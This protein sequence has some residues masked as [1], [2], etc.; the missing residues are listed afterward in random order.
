MIEVNLLPGASRR[1][2]RRGARRRTPSSF[3]KRL[4]GVDRIALFVG[5]AWI[6]SLGGF[7]WLFLGSRSEEAGLRA[8]MERAQQDS[9]RYGRVVQS[10]AH[11]TARRDTI[12][13]KLEIIQQIDADRYVW[14]HLMDEISRALPDYTWIT[15]LRPIDGEPTATFQLAGMTG[16]N[17][18]LTELLKNLEA[19]P[20]V[21][22]VNLI[23]TEQA[24]VKG[25]T[26]Y[27][28]MLQAS[29]EE[30]PPDLV[31]SAPLFAAGE[32][33]LGAATE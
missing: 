33:G 16:S 10:V 1:P 9:V 32:D 7:G 14:A 13:R 19:S 2:S 23:S 22:G 31:R 6:V 25:S 26:V 24:S 20:F 4:G 28:F 5:A 30:P 17:F 12:A 8:S 3:A 27:S 29:Y 21:R 18:A 15:S 11:L